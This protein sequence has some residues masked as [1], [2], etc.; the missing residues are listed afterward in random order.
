MADNKFGG[1]ITKYRIR[2]GYLFN[3]TK[4]LV[5]AA[6]YE[7]V[8][9]FK[10]NFGGREFRTVQDYMRLAKIPGIIGYA[11]LGKERLIQVAIYLKEF[12]G[13]TVDP[14]GAFFEKYIVFNPEEEIDV[15]EL[16]IK[17]DIAINHQRCIKAALDEITIDMI[18]SI[19][20][21][22]KEVESK[23]IKELQ[24]RKDAGQNI[25]ADFKKIVASDG[26]YKPFMTPQR[27]AEWFKNTA[28]RFISV[29]EDAIKRPE[30][31]SQLDVA[32]II[33][34]KGMLLELEEQ[35]QASAQQ[36]TGASTDTAASLTI[37]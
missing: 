21:G 12:G 26:K 31:R 30:Y 6:G 5:R 10:K 19:V 18:E 7:W 34:L 35:V 2:G 15:D 13:N 16:K 33:K 17:T 25:A 29:V 11:F 22:G 37:N 36:P 8:T 20:R 27:Q 23:H 9:W 3:A 14:V 32:L 1:T 24:V 4:E 28:N